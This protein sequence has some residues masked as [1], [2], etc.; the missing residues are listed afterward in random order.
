MTRPSWQ[1]VLSVALASAAM[2]Y[3]SL[4]V[5]ASLNGTIWRS[6]EHYWSLGTIGTTMTEQTTPRFLNRANT[7]QDAGLT[8]GE[9][10]MVASESAW[11]PWGAA[12]VPAADAG[13][14]LSYAAVSVA[15]MLLA[16]VA[17]ATGQRLSLRY[18]PLAYSHRELASRGHTDLLR[19]AQLIGSLLSLATL[20]VIYGVLWYASYDRS[21]DV[22][23]VAGTFTPSWIEH[24]IAATALFGVGCCTAARQ[25]T[26][27]LRGLHADRVCML[28]RHCGYSANGVN[29]AHCPECGRAWSLPGRD[30]ERLICR[31][32][33]GCLLFGVG[34][35][36]ALAL[37]Y[38]TQAQVQG[39][40]VPFQKTAHWLRLEGPYAAREHE[41]YLRSGRTVRFVTPSGTWAISFVRTPSETSPCP[42]ESGV[43]TLP[44]GERIVLLHRSDLLPIGPISG[45]E[46]GAWQ[47]DHN[48]TASTSPCGV[49]DFA[50]LRLTGPVL[51]LDA[52]VP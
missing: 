27:M 10:R 31:I 8:A 29:S 32:G 21:Q 30:V 50:V 5:Y 6:Y 48:D 24:G 39:W 26:R 33:L 13:W 17:G 49:A 35:A 4:G 43:L 19:R 44:S 34:G 1:F 38:R 42:D 16:L 28:C 11:N 36:M 20:P 18:G 40:L 51:D 45:F 52:T 23:P 7:F 46:T 37:G 2:L 9:S 15:M 41:I 47:F 12:Y 25:T 14:L 22:R 3:A